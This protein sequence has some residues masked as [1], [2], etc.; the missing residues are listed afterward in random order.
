[1]QRIRILYAKTTALRYT[2]NL[3][4]H[5]IWERTLRRAGLA[6]AYSQGFHPQPRLNQACPLPL[7]MTSRAEMID[8]W[9]EWA[10]TPDEINE[11]LTATLPPGIEVQEISNVKLNAPTLQGQVRSAIYE[12]ILLDECE[13]AEQKVRDLLNAPE[14]PRQRRGKAY[15]LRPLVESL[16]LY[17]TSDDEPQRLRMQLAA[18]QGA[19][20]R[21]EEVL[22]AMG[23][24][25]VTGRIERSTL[26][27]E[28]ANDDI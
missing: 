14:V 19:T 20:G 9:L 13:E 12:A 17:D 11:K 27:F 4:V 8:V 7:G 10:L 15:D 16:E 24:D 18:R 3:D 21:P 1:M 28:T 23:I 5:K 22:E 26:I 2:G 25:P 6:L